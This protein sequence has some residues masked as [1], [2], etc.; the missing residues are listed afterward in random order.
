MRLVSTVGKSNDPIC[1]VGPAGS[2]ETRSVRSEGQVKD[3]AKSSVLTWPEAF[4]PLACGQ[5][6]QPQLDLDAS[7]R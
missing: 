6:N 2:G 7:R 4:K 5:N 1:G 3:T